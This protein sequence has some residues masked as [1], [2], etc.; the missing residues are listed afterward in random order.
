MKHNIP[1][2]A[3]TTHS[4]P[5]TYDEATS[6]K[7]LEQARAN[8]DQESFNAIRNDIMMA[9]GGLVR[10]LA[11]RAC[12]YY[13]YLGLQ[14]TCTNPGGEAVFSEED[15][16]QDGYVFLAKAIDKFDRHAGTRFSTYATPVVGRG[17]N[18][19]FN[20]RALRRHSPRGCVSLDA[21]VDDEKGVAKLRDHIPDENAENAFEEFVLKDL[22]KVLKEALSSLSERERKVVLMSQGFQCD[23]IKKVDIAKI[24]GVTPQRVNQILGGALRKLRAHPAIRELRHAS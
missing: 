4:S 15:F 7:M 6:F 11:R 10:S 18:Q 24:L 3:T 12:R 13:G 20:A 14:T 5:S 23:K 8:D 17:L 2:R 9:N 16:V 1:S 19:V 21:E 22:G